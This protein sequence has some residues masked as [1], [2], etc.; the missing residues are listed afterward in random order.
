MKASEIIRLQALL[1]ALTQLDFPLSDQLQLAVKELGAALVNY[2]TDKI[3]NWEESIASLV[4]QDE[5][6][7]QIYQGERR[8]LTKD[9]ETQVRTKGFPVEND[10]PDS[11]ALPYFD[12]Q[13][14]TIG[15]ILQQPNPVEELKTTLDKSA[16]NSLDVSSSGQAP[17][18]VKL[19]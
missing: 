16:D 6:L 1:K 10:D 19:D 2:P 13:L 8:A 17:E 3:D 15:K 11:T 4:Q 12:N 14:P 7:N 5:R 9:Y 18:S